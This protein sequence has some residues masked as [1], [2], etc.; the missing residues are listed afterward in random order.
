MPAMLPTAAPVF[1]KSPTRFENRFDTSPPTTWAQRDL[2]FPTPAPTWRGLTPVP[3]IVPTAVPSIAPTF[4]S[5]LFPLPPATSVPLLTLT[6]PPKFTGSCPRWEKQ[7]CDAVQGERAGA[8]FCY[9]GGPLNHDEPWCTSQGLSGCG[10]K[11]EASGCCFVNCTVPMKQSLGPMCCTPCT[12]ST[13]APIPWTLAP[14]QANPALTW[15]RNTLPPLADPRTYT[16]MLPLTSPPTP[17]PLSRP[18]DA[19]NPTAVRPAGS[20]SLIGALLL[21]SVAAEPLRSSAAR[22]PA[23]QPTPVGTVGGGGGVSAATASDER[24]L[25][26]L[27]ASAGSLKTTAADVCT[28]AICAWLAIVALSRI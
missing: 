6:P 18:P 3:V 13:K 27:N 5:E 12:D 20:S 19:P 25:V 11:W 4:I 8:F 7:L 28:A 26:V 24:V 21:S 14:T 17:A 23:P 2:L 22:A 9:G 1:T 10:C 16:Y 15:K